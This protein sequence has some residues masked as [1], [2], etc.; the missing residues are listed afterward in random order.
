MKAAHLQAALENKKAKIP[1]KPNNGTQKLE[2]N[3]ANIENTNIPQPPKAPKAAAKAVPAAKDGGAKSGVEQQ[4][5]DEKDTALQQQTAVAENVAG[6]NTA[7]QKQPA[8]IQEQPAD[9]AETFPTLI[10]EPS[11]KT[12]AFHDDSAE[13]IAAFDEPV[14]SVE[15]VEIESNAMDLSLIFGDESK[16]SEESE[17]E[18]DI[19]TATNPA[20]EQVKATTVKKPLPSIAEIQQ[21]KNAYEEMEVQDHSVKS[22]GGVI[23]K[24]APG[25]LPPTYRNNEAYSDF[26]KKTR[27]VFYR[28]KWSLFKE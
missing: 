23:R 17:K 26:L 5:T 19:P 27:S 11:T 14:Q 4:T 8:G 20:I 15:E 9:N 6:Q 21:S 16:A 1:Q 10:R 25:R 18:E 24:P 12:S 2:Q 13:A 3:K 28:I 7:E 22:H